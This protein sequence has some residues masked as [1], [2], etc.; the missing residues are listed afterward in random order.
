VAFFRGPALTAGLA[1]LPAMMRPHGPKNTRQ[2][3][4]PAVY[5]PQGA[6]NAKRRENASTEGGQE[7]AQGTDQ[8]DLCA[9]PCRIEIVLDRA[10]SAI[11]RFACYE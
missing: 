1:S 8:D 3:A 7:G 5:C 10:E 2:L 9:S 4:C 6:Y 11:R